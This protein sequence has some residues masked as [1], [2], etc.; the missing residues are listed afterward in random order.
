MKKKSWPG[1]IFPFSNSIYAK[2]EIRN[3]VVPVGERCYQMRDE[4]YIASRP[5]QTL[6][7]NCCKTKLYIYI[8]NTNL[9]CLFLLSYFILLKIPS[10]TNEWTFTLTHNT[11]LIDIFYT[12]NRTP[13]WFA[14]LQD[15]VL[16][17]SKYSWTIN[18][19]VKREK[20]SET[21]NTNVKNKEDFKRW[22]EILSNK[23]K[24]CFKRVQVL[25]SL[26][27]KNI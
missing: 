15:L 26:W 11:E 3:I 9:I 8:Y 20:D 21:L 2:G 25:S 10:S 13:L 24:Q 27:K 17:W 12:V 1:C 16:F 6:L 18:A 7:D 19:D 22:L 4:R 23:N 14:T 5:T